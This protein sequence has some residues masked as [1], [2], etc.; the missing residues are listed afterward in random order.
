MA[1]KTISDQ[2]KIAIIVSIIIGASLVAYG[3]INYKTKIDVFEKE[4]QTKIEQLNRDE[5]A[6]RARELKLVSCKAEAEIYH[7][8]WWNNS[9]TTFG[10]NKK[11]EDCTLPS[12]IADDI[13][14]KRDKD[15]DNCVKL[16]S[17]N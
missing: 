9:C 17:A 7:N 15:M 5:Q 11:T 3:Y 1:K 12:Y 16:Y 8:N 6:Q 10:A 13:N 4:Q 14:A 2:V